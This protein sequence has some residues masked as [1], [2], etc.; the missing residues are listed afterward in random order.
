[1]RYSLFHLPAFHE[2]THGTPHGLFQQLIDEATLA[3]EIGLEKVWCA[4]HHFDAYGGDIPNPP[5]LLAAIAQATSRIKLATGG[6]AVPLHRAVDLAE[7]L[8]MVDVLSNGRLEI[9]FVRAFLAFEYDAYNVDMGESRARFN[10]GVEVIRGLFA[11]DRFSYE[12]RFSRLD[13]VALRPRP[14]QR[15]PR[16]TVGAI[17]TKESFEFAAQN[18]MDLMVIP[19]AFPLKAVAANVGIYR[20]ALRGAGH[21]PDDFN[22]MAP[23]FYYSEADPQ[24]AKETP[25]E[26]T[27]NY[28]GYARDAVAEDRW[29]ADYQGYQGMVKIFESL[30]DYELMYGER[31]LYGPPEKFQAMVEQI[32][33]AGITEV[34]LM[35]NMPGIPHDKVMRSLE[36][37]GREILPDAT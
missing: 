19:Y 26:A 25:R 11:N 13:D 1:M 7:Q 34:A 18:A 2:P 10:E 37:L 36:F 23:Y 30:M 5:V 9:G 22:V 6:V 17:A 16:M 20:D 27:L 8:A 28:L 35:P 31:T 14:V 29:S 12:G 24:A 3:D 32:A 33:E 21:D 15:R 4:E